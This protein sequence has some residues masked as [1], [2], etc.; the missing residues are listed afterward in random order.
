VASGH[1]L[2]QSCNAEGDLESD[3][4]MT[5]GELIGYCALLVGCQAQDER[6]GGRLDEES[7][8]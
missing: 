5:G 1:R 7:W 6:I 8:R 3:N 2:S 4:A